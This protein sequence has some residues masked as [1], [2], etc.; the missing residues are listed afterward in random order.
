MAWTKAKM[1]VVVGASVLL[2]AGTT[3]VT[4]EQIHEH[5]NDAWRLGQMNTTFLYKLRHQTTILPAKIK[6]SAHGM[7][8][9]ENG[10]VMGYNQPMEFMVR[11]AAIQNGMVGQYR[12]LLATDF[13]TNK[14]DFISNLPT[15]SKAALA[16]ELRRKFQVASRF[17][18]LETNVLFL[19]VKN[20][21]AAGL[22]PTTVEVASSSAGNGVI[23]EEDCIMDELAHQLENLCALPVINQTGLTNRYDFKIRWREGERF[24][25]NDPDYQN[26]PGLKQ[27]LTEQLGLELVPGTAPVEMLVVE[28]V[29]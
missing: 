24:G 19:K 15:G 5:Q 29:K 12:T 9:F 22:K 21:N 27:A 4:V 3:T 26:V 16:R 23:T 2:A 7:A 1:A 28:K 18:T 20:A 6:S 8:W 13:P 17:E 10:Q 14:Y 25:G 11:A